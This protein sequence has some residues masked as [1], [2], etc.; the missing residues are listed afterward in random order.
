MNRTEAQQKALERQ[1]KKRKGSP[2]FS[3]IRLDS[4]EQKEFIDQA[5]SKFG[6]RKDALIKAAEL[7]MRID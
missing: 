1:N 5:F 3:A 7:L 2:T 4:E 6:T